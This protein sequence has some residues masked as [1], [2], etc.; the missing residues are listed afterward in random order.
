MKIKSSFYK[1]YKSISLIP[2]V[3]F[4]WDRDLFFE[5]AIDFLL[6]KFTIFT[7]NR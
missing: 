4:S 3:Y 6:W 7:D 2:S 1:M 5:I